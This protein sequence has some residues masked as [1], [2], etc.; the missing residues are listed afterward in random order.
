MEKL[1][2]K[3]K[4]FFALFSKTQIILP[5]F[6]DVKLIPYEAPKI[7]D[8]PEVVIL[9]NP[10]A[11]DEPKIDI[12]PSVHSNGSKKHVSIEI[13]KPAKKKPAA[14]KVILPKKKS[15]KNGRKKK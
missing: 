5:Q 15:K 9:H 4:A 1:I 11:S 12:L 6:Y 8:G 13:K 2:E 14:K 10:G 7:E 3:V